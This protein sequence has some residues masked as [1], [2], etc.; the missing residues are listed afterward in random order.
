MTHILK[1]QARRNPG[2]LSLPLFFDKIPWPKLLL[3]GERSILAY[4]S[5]CSPSW[6]KGHELEAAG[7]VTSTVR[8][9]EDQVRAHWLALP[10]QCLYCWGSGYDIVLSKFRV[11][12]PT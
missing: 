11:G 12:L 8:S 6:S 5:K 10:F 3:K 7:H 9:S 2:E 4:R 1:G